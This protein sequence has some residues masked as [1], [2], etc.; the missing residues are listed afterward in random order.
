MKTT[1]TTLLALIVFA[2][3]TNK[4]EPKPIYEA[5]NYWYSG[6]GCKEIITYVHGA[7]QAVKQPDGTYKS[8]WFHAGIHT[9]DSLGVQRSY[10]FGTLEA[11]EFSKYHVNE[12]YK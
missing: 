11:S 4:E 2:S 1:I 9:Q 6:C 8:Y 10:P 7:V 12:C 5:Y 3:C